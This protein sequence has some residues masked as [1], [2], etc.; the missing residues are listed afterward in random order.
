MIVVLDT[1]AFRGDVYA[2]RS[3][4]RAIRERATAGDYT[5]AVPRVCVEEL[6]RQFPLRVQALGK[7]V[8]DVS[9]SLRAFG[10]VP[11]VLPDPQLA[12]AEY[13]GRLEERL[14][15]DGCRI[16]GYP[17]DAYLA[18]EWTAQRR[19]PIKDGG[20]DDGKG[21]PDA[22]IWLTV[23]AFAREEKVVLVTANSSDF[24]EHRGS[25]IV[26][27]TL[28]A[29]LRQRGIDPD[30]V[31]LIPNLFEFIARHI[32]PAQDAKAQA[33]A[34]LADQA[35]F[36]TLRAEI[37]DAAQWYQIPDRQLEGWSPGVDIETAHLADVEV[38]DIELVAVERSRNSLDLLLRATCDARLDL[39]IWKYDAYGLPDEHPIRVY[40]FNWNESMAAA[41]MAHEIVLDLQCE[42][43]TADERFA[44]EI[45][46]IA[47]A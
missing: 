15:G 20:N 11:P 36:E 37:S 42:H 9:G 47:L 23:L 17:D 32:P 22:V 27:P 39:M 25:T 29:D 33:E 41:E 6:V 45:V 13:P 38:S 2:E 40:D 28:L 34:L 44:I 10:L 8:K 19:K 24:A 43:D 26:H 18:A 46:E 35:T 5:I 12:I 1:N 21:T 7:D 14:S 31:E 16:A 3:Q 4:L 30:R